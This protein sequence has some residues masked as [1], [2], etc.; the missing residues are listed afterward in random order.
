MTVASSAVP[1]AVD[2][3]P[4]EARSDEQADEPMT[5]FPLD[6]LPEPIKRFTAE[7]AK[8]LS[9]AP[10]LVAVP[11]LVTLSA[12][13]GNAR[14]I[15]L[16]ADYE[17]SAALFAALVA[18]TGSM[19]SPALRM[20]TEPLVNAQTEDRRT[21]TADTTV[22]KLAELL[23]ENKRGLA[24]VRDELIGWV[25]SLNQYR[26]GKGG[27]P[28]FYLSA[29]SGAAL[30]VD[31]KSNEK[32]L[33]VPRPFLSVVGCLPPDLLDG[34]EGTAK[35][36]GFIQRFL[37][38]WPEPVPVRWKDL[39]VTDA[40]RKAY[41]DL[42]TQLVG[43]DWQGEE[44]VPIPL[45]PRALVLYKDWY[46]QHCTEMES[47]ELLP[48][49][50]LFYPKL[51]GYCARLAL[52]HALATDP[53]EEEIGPRHIEAAI[54]QINYFKNQ[55]ARVAGRLCR[56]VGVGDQVQRCGM[57]IFRKAG[58]GQ[59]ISHRALQRSSQFDAG[60]FNAAWDDIASRV[61][62]L[63]REGTDAP[64]TDKVA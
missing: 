2:A 45:T 3:L 39:A 24:I 29:W 63:F 40:A 54:A 57:E 62:P 36:D 18:D 43:L 33:I 50:K 10:E 5:A 55:A 59:N 64:T 32:P 26:D 19:K 31:R 30:A 53:E 11:A 41:H 60:V 38:A 7:C 37:F 51:K 23:R 44:P 12:A 34:L 13:I 49:L 16:K 15:R 4:T 6:A 14:W 35:D 22:E 17:E 58:R 46:D 9:V 42:V 28:E 56:S 61:I 20:A 52:I 8:S 48:G 1:P 25:K 47:P 21:W 27:D